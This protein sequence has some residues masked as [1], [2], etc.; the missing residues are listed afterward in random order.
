[1]AGS[2]ADAWYVPL[3]G[4]LNQGDIVRV[5]PAGLIDAP[6]T[7]CQPLNNDPKGRANYYPHDQVPKKRSVEFLHAK[8]DIALGM[9]VWPDCQIDKLK[10][11]KKP[12]AKWFAAIA[13]I[14]PLSVVRDTSKHEA[15]R[16]LGRRAFFPL[17]PK[18]PEL[19]EESY[20]DLR[21]IWSVRYALLANRVMGLSEDALHALRSHLFWFMT[22][23]RLVDLAQCPHCAGEFP[24]RSAIQHGPP[25]VE[26]DDA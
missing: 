7:I 16:T 9:V 18:D 23:S 19:P 10:N 11:R 21:Y 5:V 6:L 13:P 12:E 1:M 4:H 2:A 25:D 15:I 3:N 20:V 8:A 24:L 26:E 17:P 22:E 14:K